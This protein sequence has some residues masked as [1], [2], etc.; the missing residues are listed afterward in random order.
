ML[1]ARHRVGKAEKRAAR[2]VGRAD[3]F[4]CIA[5]PMARRSVRSSS[6]MRRPCGDHSDAAVGKNY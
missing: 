1:L 3:G 4:R 5:G 2:R 6:V